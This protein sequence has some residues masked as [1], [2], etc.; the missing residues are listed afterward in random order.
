MIEHAVKHIKNAHSIMFIT[1]AGISADSGLPTYRG[2]GGLYEDAFTEEGI[3]IE[4]ALA[5]EMLAK[6]PQVTWK[7]LSQ[8]EQNCRKAT[9]NQGHAV[10]AAMEKKFKRVWTLTQNIDGFHAAAG[11]SNVIEIHG[12][13]RRLRCD[14][15]GWKLN[16][17]NFSEIQIPP[18]CPD[19]QHIARPDVVFFGEMLPEQ[20]VQIYEEQL[21]QKFDVY[22]WIGT[23]CVFP[24]IQTPLYLARRHGGVTIEI[25]PGDTEISTQVDIKISSS[26]ASALQEIW[27][28]SQ[29]S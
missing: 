25:N 18:P 8:I 3:P 11:S 23:T 6:H 21:R 20:A 29:Q 19:C 14:H 5:G 17:Q 2:I 27:Q 26:A 22:I 24:Y 16:I 13:M 9:F 28:L 7:Y 10:I 1:G 4:M 12:N 15:C